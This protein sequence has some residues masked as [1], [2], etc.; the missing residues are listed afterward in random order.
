MTQPPRSVLRKGE[1][2]AGAAPAVPKEGSTESPAA[3]RVP[4]WS[5]PWRAPGGPFSRPF[6]PPSPVGR[7]GPRAKRG[8][9]RVA[10]VFFLAID[11]LVSLSFRTITAR[12]RRLLGISLFNWSG[13]IQAVPSIQNMLTSIQNTIS[14]AMGSRYHA[15]NTV[16]P[17]RRVLYVTRG[18]WCGHLI[19]L[20]ACAKSRSKFGNQPMQLKP[21]QIDTFPISSVAYF[22]HICYL[23]L[24][25]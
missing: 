11:S 13:K 21:L 6:A 18:R 5:R 17:T 4:L 9:S 20:V 24:L 12:P 14:D 7:R 19:Q 2:S 10:I 23:I 16:V 22:P 1:F 3:A 25:A 8:A 15:T